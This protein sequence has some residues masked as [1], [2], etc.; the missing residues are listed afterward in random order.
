MPIPSL[1]E[2]Y[3]KI[4]GIIPFSLA[5]FVFFL[6]WGFVS[7][8]YSIK[9]KEWA[10]SYAMFGLVVSLWGVVRFIVDTPVGVACDKH[11]RKKILELSLLAYVLISLAY[12]LVRDLVTVFSLRI[13]HSLAG[14]LLWVSTWSMIREITPEGVEETNIGFY[15]TFT[16]IASL[17]GPIIGGF[18]I[19]LYSWQASFYLL[20]AS[21]FVAFLIIR[22][23]K[24]KELETRDGRMIELFKKSIKDFLGFG[25]K[26]MTLV[27]LT[28]VFFS[29]LSFIGSFAPV[30]LEEK[31]LHVLE[32]GFIIGVAINLSYI[33]FPLPVGVLA[34]KYGRGNAVLAGLVLST[35]GFLAFTASHGFASLFLSTFIIYSGFSFIS[36]TIDAVV[37]DMLIP[38]QAGGFAGITETFKDLGRVMGPLLGGL[39]VSILG[40]ESLL[41]ACS[42]LL[43]G[44]MMMLFMD[45]RRKKG[46]F[47][48]KNF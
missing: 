27:A 44:I 4:K 42:L 43:V 2:N 15:S 31:G 38:G 35:L 11:N 26:S 13:V 22:S 34:D 1:H 3:Q 33:L 39:L 21:C 47:K 8:I 25:K 12:T 17:L 32:I 10:G 36:P 37:D 46:F 28:V 6:G 23:S 5:F 18:V 16:S 7:P 29:T 45:W 14:S 30:F 24:I 9:I 41:V 40:R 19:T 20:S 48:S